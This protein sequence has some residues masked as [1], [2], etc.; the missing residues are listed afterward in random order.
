MFKKTSPKAQLNAFSSPN[1]FLP[2]RAEQF[3]EQIGAWHNLFFKQVTLRVEE[4][5]FEPLFSKGFGRPN[6]S[7]R[8]L[9]A[10]MVLKEASRWSDSQLFEQCRF[11]LLVRRALG[12]NNL[13]DLLPSKST[14][15]L[16][17]KY[18][19]EYEK[20]G[21][22]NLLEQT[23]TAIT[24]GQAKEFEVS[25]RSI[26]MDSKLLGSNIA[27]LSRY[28]L[29]HES[30]RLFCSEVDFTKLSGTSCLSSSDIELVKSILAEKGNKVVYRS[31]GEEVKAKLI[32]L[33]LLTYRLLNVLEGSSSEHYKTVSRLFKEQ[34]EVCEE[35]TVIPKP[36]ESISADSIQSPH[37]TDCSYRNKD[38]NQV[39]GYSINLT[40]S[41]DKTG[42]NLISGVAVKTADA[43]DNGYLEQGVVQAGE[44]FC[45][46]V[47]NIHTDG[48]Y[49]S[50]T[51]QEFVLDREAQFF[52][53]AIQ[54]AKP[55]YDLELDEKGVLTVID[56]KTEVAVEAVK[57]KESE[58]WRIKTASQ[59]RYFT[60]KEIITC[61]L[62]KKIAAIPQEILNIRNN[63]EATIFQL[64]YHY[65]NDKTRYRGL[66][67]HKMW[68]N[69]RC[70]WVNFVRIVKHVHKTAPKG[71]FCPKNNLS[72]LPGRIK[73]E[74][75][76]II[77]VLRPTY[78]IQITIT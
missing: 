53:N 66:I 29:V 59:Y 5:L 67:K 8:I 46:A 61:Q 75:R 16:F 4:A 22:P 50:E 60:A 43:A 34:F 77:R 45:D 65:S 30:L 17:R 15:Y 70:L 55:R 3:Y 62:R 63:V 78:G 73:I 48:A 42:L 49:H 14:Y 6:S 64:G 41:C 21:N 36:K 7:V 23:F 37:D 2:E 51:N 31:S 54:G 52:L 38:G 56:L 39:K 76:A 40:E 69:M 19:V 20:L 71:T 18:I 44:I 47:K 35:K 28:E 11:N 13:N 25:G 1:S 72:T 74:F 33:G 58:K 32:D 68:A 26:R 24:K 27:W 57:L 10:M 12:L 9:V